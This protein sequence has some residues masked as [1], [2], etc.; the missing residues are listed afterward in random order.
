MT[1]AA[2]QRPLPPSRP[3]ASLRRA[4]G[5][6]PAFY[7]IFRLPSLCSTASTADRQGR[8]HARTTVSAT[9]AQRN[10]PA[11]A[12]AGTAAS[13]PT[14]QQKNRFAMLGAAVRGAAVVFA[15][16][17]A[18]CAAVTRQAGERWKMKSDGMRQVVACMASMSWSAQRES[19]P[20]SR[21]RRPLSYPL[22]DGRKGAV[23]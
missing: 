15:Q 11:L 6:R 3:A 20:H 17:G 1:A 21:F 2:Q 14:G 23:F 5:A 7:T 19:N 13:G 18:V 12:C 4:C 22:N 9:R 16:R 10:P 8:T